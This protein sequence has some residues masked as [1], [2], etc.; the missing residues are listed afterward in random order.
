MKNTFFGILI[1]T[2][3]CVIALLSYLLVHLGKT[4]KADHAVI[5]QIVN[6]INSSQKAPAASPAK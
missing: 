1:G 3:L 2:A 4:V 5:G 6:L